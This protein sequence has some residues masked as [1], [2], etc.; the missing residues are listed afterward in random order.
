MES[1]GVER[2]RRAHWA[3]PENVQT[4]LRAGRGDGQRCQRESASVV[5]CTAASSGFGPIPMP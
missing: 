1:I 2:A 3:A 5:A 4:C